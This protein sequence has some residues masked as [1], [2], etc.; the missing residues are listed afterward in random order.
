MI[1]EG[2]GKDFQEDVE[3]VVWLKDHLCVPNVES[4]RELILTEAHETFYSIHLESEK[5]Y[6]DLKKKILVV[7]N[8]K[9]DRRAHGYM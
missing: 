4:I 9:G 7:Q 6:Q 8:E 3:G 5:M 2:R 1:L